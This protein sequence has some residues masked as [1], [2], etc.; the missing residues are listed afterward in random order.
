MI[1]D[2]RRQVDARIICLEVGVSTCASLRC[3]GEEGEEVEDSETQW[4]V[5]AVRSAGKSFCVWTDRVR[6]R[7]EA[8]RGE[9]TCFESSSV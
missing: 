1:V 8:K 4:R 7:A 9:R 6:K 3:K 5:H 2:R